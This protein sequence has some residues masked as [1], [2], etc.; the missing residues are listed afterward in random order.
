[1]KHKLPESFTPSRTFLS[2]ERLE[3]ESFEDYKRRRKAGNAYVNQT[4]TKMFWDSYNQGTYACRPNAVQH[5]QG[6]C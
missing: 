3:E 5:G 1:M 6:I 4:R 2:P